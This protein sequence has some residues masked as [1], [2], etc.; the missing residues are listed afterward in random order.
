M[1]VLVNTTH[2]GWESSNWW[3]WRVGFLHFLPPSSQ[4]PTL[5]SVMV[6]FLP[7]KPSWFPTKLQP[8]FTLLLISNLYNPLFMRGWTLMSTMVYSIC[9]EILTITLDAWE[10]RD[11]WAKKLDGSARAI[12]WGC[13][14]TVS[15]ITLGS[16]LLPTEAEL[17]W[18][19]KE[20]ARQGHG[21]TTNASSGEFTNGSLIH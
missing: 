7:T 2:R 6:V 14:T 5:M 8:N 1:V 17:M 12:M 10:R 13:R 3:H 9:A 20:T 15:R 16:W 4:P 18:S 21:R 19:G 11:S